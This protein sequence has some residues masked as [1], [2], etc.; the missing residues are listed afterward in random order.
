MRLSKGSAALSMMLV[1]QLLLAAVVSAGPYDPGLH[2]TAN[3]AKGE[4]M[5][6]A[7]IINDFNTAADVA[8]WKAGTNTKQIN[9]AT[10]ILNGPNSPYEGAG[11]LEQ[12]PEKVKVYDWRTIYRS[13][14]EPLDL[15][16]YR[17]LALAANSWGWQASA[18]Y[19]LKVNLYSGDDRLESVA[20]IRPDRWDRI[21]IKLGDWPGKG[22]VAKM[23]IS[24]MQ[25]FDLA[26]IEPGAPGYDYWDGRF[27]I[28]CIAA[29]NVLDLSFTGE[30][31]T[32]GFTSPSGDV[33]A[34]GGALVYR[35]NGEAGVLESPA[36]RLDAG[37]RNG[38]AVAMT[39]GTGAGEL[40]VQWKMDGGDWSVERSKTFAI[41]TEGAFTREFNFSDNPAWSGRLT[42]FRFLLPASTGTLAIDQIRFKS[43]PVLEAPYPAQA[44]A[45]IEGADR[46]A[47][48]GSVDPSYVGAHPGEQLYLFELATYEDPKAF[49]A[50]K[51]PIAEVELASA[52]AFET[53]LSEGERSRLYSKFAV[54]SK[55]AD[56]AYTLLAAPQYVA[57][58]EETAANWEPYPSARSIKGL[59]VQMTGDAQELGI[60]H[61]ALNVAYNELTYKAGN[62]PENTIAYEVEGKPYY[63]RKDR[64]E[65]LDRQIKSLSDNGILVSLILIMYDSKDP[66]S[67]NE[68][69]LHPD[70][71]PGGTVYALNT[72]NEKGVAY[73][74]AVTK[75]LA[76]RYSEQNQAHGRA[77]NY[78]VGNEIGQ[79]KVWNNMGPKKIGDYVREYAQT[80]RLIDTIVKSAYANART[81]VSLDHFWNENLGDDSLWKYDN[82]AIV[83]RLTQLT[84]AEGD[85]GW[86]IAFHP[87]P[88]NLFEPR[89]W[90]DKTATASFDTERITF[91]NLDVLVDYMKQPDYLYDGAMRR[92][93]LSEQGFH[94]LSNSEA[95]QQVQAAAYAYA[96]YKVKFLDGIDAFI[97]H[98]HVDH[99][100]EGGLNLGLW[101]HAPGTV[102]T[103]Y[104]H[105]VSYDVFQAIDTDRSLEATAFAKAIIGIRD[106]SDAI[107]NFDPSKLADR[108]WPQLNGLDFIERIHA[109][110]K[111]DKFGEIAG[112]ESG[113]DG[114]QASDEV[115][116]I[117][118]DTGDAYAGAGYLTAK[119]NSAYAMNWA[120]VQR[121]FA[122]PV[123]AAK[124]P[125][126]TAAIRLPGADANN[127]YD[128]KFI[129]YSGAD[130]V[131]G[132][133]K[134]NPAAGWAPLA[135][136]L[137]GWKGAGAVDRVKIWVRSE[138]GAPWKGEIQIDEA[139]FAKTVK[140]DAKHPNVEVEAKLASPKLEAG[141]QIAV[142]VTNRSPDPLKKMQVE[143]SKGLKL[144]PKSLTLEGL[145]TDQR[146]TFTLQ[147]SEYDP[148]EG[149]APSVT[150]KVQDAEF[151]FVL[152]DSPPGGGPADG[153]LYTFEDG[154][155]GWTAGENVASVTT[156]TSFPNGPGTPSEGQSALSARS[157]SVA[158]SA[159]RTVQAAPGRPLDLSGAS[160]FAYDID[161]YGGVPNASYETR[162]TLRSGDGD[163]Y[164]FNASVAPDQ[165]N[166]IE[167][168][169]AG[170]AGRTSVQQIEIAFRA[171][172]S[173]MAW[174]PEFQLDRIGAYA[175][176]AD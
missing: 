101:T 18:D 94:S 52:F 155:Q 169:I 119:V 102:V 150:L 168:P 39:N 4:E 176:A 110:G 151:T 88:E 19:V 157:A 109:G 5:Y 139:G 165:W 28:D 133:A 59:Q 67:A 162:V 144:E 143:A 160:V 127:V 117:R 93:I 61:A 103:P 149:E 130:S 138:G 63:F 46:I 75:F 17:Y 106:W 145:G 81:Y 126:F 49:L 175:S 118:V 8:T 21:F 42:A 83:D 85:F 142:A 14:E 78:I 34:T 57:N 20:T 33:S 129:A 24:F 1:L 82:K 84:R 23:E 134:L 62:H 58:P 43:L 135:L 120:G 128:A 161:A 7:R 44:K 6:P 116:E 64:I 147:V 31:D 104:R 156:V 65:Q 172:G 122:S 100:Q 173:D 68:Y 48:A 105:K 76:E 16:G 164:T 3:V 96:Y 80:L 159:W 148:K 37:Q 121:T 12:V 9:F 152:Q 50:A 146:K 74:K 11:A 53:G 158:A 111:D 141:A 71:Q 123:D 79:N 171:A 25:N 170:W 40:T 87:Y 140:A 153:L 90:N 91:K 98:R 56:G 15:S 108:S 69:L 22:T 136:P 38:M 174:N 125:Y 86:N 55:A 72:A 73:V 112:F 70:A 66:E 2:A 132:T 154:V 27:Q 51:T 41:P 60:S 45:R 13:F 131:E 36:L 32:E 166:R 113:T 92:I 114:Y 54:A 47:V 77:V 97:L 95:D 115:S 89:F 124:T 29:T 137:R 107:P 163:V 167:A 35:M 26:G 10:S 99:G 30:G